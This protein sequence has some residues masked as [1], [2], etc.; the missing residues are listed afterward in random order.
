M[1]VIVTGGTDLIGSA[2][3]ASLA[4]D[5][6]EVI[7]L[8]R[9][10]DRAPALPSGVQVVGWDAR[11]ASGWGH[12][13]DGVDGIVNLAGASIAGLW[14]SERRRRI[15]DSRLHAGQAIVE[16]VG[17]AKVKPRVLIQSSGIGIYGACADDITREGAAPGRDFLAQMAVDWEAAVAP[18]QAHG[19]RVATIRTGMVMSM[20]GGAFPLM[21]W[22]FRLFVGGHLGNGSQWLPWIHMDDEVGAIR[23]LLENDAAE[24]P[25]NLVAPQTLRN[26]QFS[27]LLGKV[28]RRPSWLHMPAFFFRLL[29]GEMSI[30]LLAGQRAVPEKLQGLG[31]EFRYPTAEPALRDALGR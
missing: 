21:V 25:F 17:A 27:D 20:K 1:R 7:V 18:V 26:A 15:R 4:A 31:Y 13:A 16:A 30:L 3:V 10:P 14:T 24:G 9:S 8:S 6:H 19:V 23:F 22:P 11:T 2:L 29:L 5:Q 12:L 28:M